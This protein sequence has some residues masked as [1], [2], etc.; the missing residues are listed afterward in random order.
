M[1][2]GVIGINEK[3]AGL[4][5]REK[6][7]KACQQRF[8]ADIHTPNDLSVVLLST[9]NRTELYFSSLDVAQSHQDLLKL[10]KHD[11]AEDF[12]QLL[13]SYFGKDCLRHLSRV[14]AGLDSAILA[15]TEIQGQVRTAYENTAKSRSLPHELHFAF[16]K[17]LKVGKQVRRTL[18]MTRG[19]PDLEHAIMGA[20]AQIF[21]KPEATKVLFVG[22]SEIN[23]KVLA[24]MKLRGVLDITL[25]NRSYDTAQAMAH[26]H[27]ITPL[28]WEMISSWKQYDWVVFGTKSPDYLVAR[29][30]LQGVQVNTRL[31]IDLSVPRNVAPTVAQDP[32]IT[33]L[34]I[35]QLHQR[36]RAR[37]KKLTHLLECGESIVDTCVDRQMASFTKSQAR[38]Q[39]MLQPA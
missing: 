24:F 21:P 16:Q 29:K 8:H 23:H 14:A 2:I 3:V 30:D 17:A 22:A 25:C 10:L 12:D 32:R 27:G 11:L 6:L 18:P 19:M 39:R 1:L 28:P 4:K 37:S 36:L 13:Y 34:N 26:K 38:R 5:L 7:A 9:C 15:E 33:L 35:D 20:G 31:L